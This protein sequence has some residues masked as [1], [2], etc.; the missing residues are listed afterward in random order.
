MQILRSCAILAFLRVTKEVALPS[1]PTTNPVHVV[2]DRFGH[3]EVDNHGNIL[4]VNVADTLVCVHKNH[5]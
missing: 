1:L 5:F 4:S 3:V 2:V